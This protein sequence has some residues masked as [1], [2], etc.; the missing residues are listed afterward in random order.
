[1]YYQQL[2]AT[3][4]FTLTATMTVKEF[5]VNTQVGFG[6][7]IRD[8]MYVDVQTANNSSMDFVRFLALLSNYK[9]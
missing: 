2:S 5:D 3:S 7:M 6:I 1:M 9:S 8:D 4:N